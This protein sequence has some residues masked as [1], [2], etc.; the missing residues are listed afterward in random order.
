[1]NNFPV[2]VTAALWEPPQAISMICWSFNAL[3]YKIHQLKI[4]YSKQHQ[5]YPN[6][7]NQTWFIAIC[8]VS[9]PEFSIF[10]VAPGENSTSW[11]QSKG[12][13]SSWIVTNQIGGCS[14]LM[15]DKLNNSPLWI[16]T[17][18]IKYDVK[19]EMNVGTVMLDDTTP[20]PSRPF[21]DSP[22]E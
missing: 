20:S 3:I 9:V 4:N 10:T 18:V 2:T 16:A 11:G 19:C 17:L 15:R 6:Y 22:H 1:M 5:N 7:R 8:S 13:S 14:L 21:V 12:V